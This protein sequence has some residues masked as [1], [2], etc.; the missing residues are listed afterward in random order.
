MSRNWRPGRLRTHRL[1][2]PGTPLRWHRRL[3]TRK[4]THLNRTG[5]RQSAPTSRRSSSGSLPAKAAGGTR[6]STELLKLAYGVRASMI[7]RISKGLK[8]SSVATGGAPPRPDRAADFR[9]LLR[10]RDWQFTV[11]RRAPGKRWRPGR[12][13]PAPR[14]ARQCLCGKAAYGPP[15]RWPLP[16][17]DP[18]LACPR[19]LIRRI[20]A[21]R[22]KSPG[23][24]GWPGSGIPQAAGRGC[25]AAHGGLK[26][27]IWAM[28]V[29]M[30]SAAHSSLILPSVTR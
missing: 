17:A 14:P 2:A 25:Q 16:G 23:R 18:A 27:P 9:F 13:D 6:G 29:A 21:S 30:S 26:A 8:I 15:F 28:I 4:R 3:V 12:E 10:D 1:V 5:G 19:G 22:L 7:R 11:L 20:R 24:T